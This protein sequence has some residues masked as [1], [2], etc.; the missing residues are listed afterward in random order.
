M[1]RR[2]LLAALV[3]MMMPLPA[4]AGSSSG[5]GIEMNGNVLPKEIVFRFLPTQVP[6]TSIRVT[7]LYGL[8]QDPIHSY[9]RMHRGVDFAAAVGTQVYATGAGIVRRAGKVGKYG[10]MVEIEH[11]LGFASRYGHLSRLEIKEGMAVDRG[12]PIARS[13]NTGRSTG[14]HLHYEILSDGEQIDPVRFLIRVHEVY[15]HLQ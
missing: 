3:G 4:I 6:L 11:G 13:G 5:R 14:P 10:L 1:R 2:D 7:S 8:R 12:M 9:T 15:K